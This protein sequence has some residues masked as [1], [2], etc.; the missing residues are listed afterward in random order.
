M[1]LS[2]RGTLT[3]VAKDEVEHVEVLGAEDVAVAAAVVGVAVADGGGGRGEHE[4]VN[5]LGDVAPAHDAPLHQAQRKRLQRARQAVYGQLHAPRLLLHQ[6]CQAPCGECNDQGLVGEHTTDILEKRI[7]T[8]STS[9]GKTS[10]TPQSC[11]IKH[12]K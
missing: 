9:L 1:R 12:N 6:G 11:C 5:A 4:H 10:K 3:G 8:P 7:P 2:T